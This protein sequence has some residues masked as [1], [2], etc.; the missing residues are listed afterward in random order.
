MD[1]KWK[2]KWIVVV[3]LLLFSH[4]LSGIMMALNQGE[5]YIAKDYFQSDPFQSE[6]HHFINTL[7]T[8]ELNYIPKDEV[9]KQITVTPEEIDEHRFRYGNLEEQIANIKEQYIGK[10]EQAEATGNQEAADAYSK[11][12][13]KKIA[14]ITM[15]FQSDE[16]VRGKVVKEKEQQIENYYRD[17]ERLRADYLKFK[18]V[19][20][21][22]LKDTET[23][24][25]YSNTKDQA[26]EANKMGFILTYPSSNLGYLVT[27]GRTAESGHFTQPIPVSKAGIFEGQIAVPKSLVS[28]GDSAL[29][30]YYDFNFKQKLFYG[31][32]I[33]GI[34]AFLISFYLLKKIPVLSFIAPIR[35]QSYYNRVPIDVR[36]GMIA[37]TGLITL[38]ILR[39]SASFLHHFMYDRFAEWL[40]DLGFTTLFHGAHPWTREISLGPNSRGHTPGS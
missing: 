30:G 6:L 9:T 12:R 29:Q 36:A 11:E 35:W 27:E 25:V 32:T 26:I 14:D 13:D 16:Y 40:F 1:T 7:S 28:G 39:N 10:I 8:F 15:N 17:L 2:N 31:Y 38:L 33:S 19:F 37:F 3:W 18:G 34:A 4:G 5:N 24:Q 22:V 20:L 23:G 21:Y